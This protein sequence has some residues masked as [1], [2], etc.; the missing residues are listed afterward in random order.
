MLTSN[1]S[2]DYHIVIFLLY[3]CIFYCS[4]AMKLRTCKIHFI[5]ILSKML[6]LTVVKNYFY[7]FF[8]VFYFHTLLIYFSG[9]ANVTCLPSIISQMLSDWKNCST[10]HLSI[11]QFSDA[12]HFGCKY[13]VSVNTGA[14]Q[15]VNTTFY[16]SARISDKTNA[17]SPLLR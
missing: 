6:F 5:C 2:T 1:K 13:E 10:I 7:I 17:A 14:L 12:W 15:R 16:S 9:V 3:I 8:T 11:L 4:M